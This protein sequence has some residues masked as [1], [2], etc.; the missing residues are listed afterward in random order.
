MENTLFGF[1]CSSCGSGP[2][3]YPKLKKGYEIFAFE[4]A[5]SWMETLTAEDGS[6]VDS[7]RFI[8]AEQAPVKGKESVVLVRFPFNYAIGDTFWGLFSPPD[9]FLNGWEKRNQHEI[10]ESAFVRC[11]FLS[12][13]SDN[14]N[15][16]YIKV[17]I[18]DVLFLNQMDT[19]LD[20]QNGSGF[21]KDMGMFR[22]LD[23]DQFEEWLYFSDGAEG[24]IGIWALLHIL[25]T[26]YRLVAYGDWSFHEN[27]IYGGNLKIPAAEVDML[28]S[29]AKEIK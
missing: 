16:A 20:E 13:V 24:D 10:N 5:I 6:L 27:Y 29:Q 11:T 1:T 17:M 15:N 14:I 8:L 2:P 25:E 21:L 12:V 28:I 19:H 4:Q 3:V 18:E 26:D 9:S 7:E 23:L 22:G